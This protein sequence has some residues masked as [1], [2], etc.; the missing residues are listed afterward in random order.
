MVR[1]ALNYIITLTLEAHPEI[2]LDSYDRIIPNQGTLPKGGFGNL[3]ALPLQAE[4]RKIDNSVFVNDDWVAYKDQWQ[5]LASVRRIEK[6]E[7][8]R[9]R[10]GRRRNIV[11]LSRPV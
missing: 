1:A 3:I 6:G 10:I 2:S 5:F 4:A 7:I 9:L 8:Y 11:L